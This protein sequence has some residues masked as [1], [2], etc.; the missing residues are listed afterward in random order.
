ME[1]EKWSDI[2]PSFIRVPITAYKY[3]TTIQKWWKKA[4]AY[5]NRG[6]TNVVVLGRSNVGKSVMMAYLYG[7]SNDMSWKLPKEAS[8]EVEV[9]TLTLGAWTKLIRVIP[10]QGFAK[11]FKGLNEA[12]NKHEN[13]EG[14][15]YVVDWGYTDQRDPVAK[16]I[17]IEDDKIDS[18]D[19]L[20]ELNLSEELQDFRTVCN[21]IKEAF[22]IGK[23][24]KWLLIVANKADL[25]FD[26]N[27]LNKAQ[28]YYH[29]KGQSPFSKIIQE[30][31]EQVGEQNLKCAS[32]PLCS[33][34]KSLEWNKEKIETKIKGEE[35]RKALAMHFFNIIANF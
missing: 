17:Y 8:N 16:N 11:R 23:A 14:V 4:L 2:A 34:E 26:E 13:L 12:F 5:A 31:L 19:K 27:E 25:F 7:E 21:K 3:R 33:Y 24:P 35:N 28:N 6:N 20:R 30:L 29:P 9:G 10:G 32:L 15:I 1:F 22:A 18:I